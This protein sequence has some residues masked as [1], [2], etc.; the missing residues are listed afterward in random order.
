MRIDRKGL[1]WSARDAMRAAQPNAMLMTF[2]YLL[3]TA[4][5]TVVVGLLVTD[6]VGEVM[7]LYQRGLPLERA[8][9]L[10]VAGVGSV[11]LFANILMFIFGLVV[12]FGYRNWCLAT[13]RGEQGELGN[14][15]DGFSMVG[16]IL[17]LRILIMLY[18]FL[19]YLAIFMP[20]L[21]GVLA[22]TLIPGIGPLV[23][24][25]VFLI[26]VAAYISR[27]LRYS[28]S[29]YCLADEPEMGASWALRRSKWMMEGHVKDYFLLR[30]S[31][32]GW[33][34]LG[35]LLVTAVEGAV[36]AV[37]GG[38]HLLMET[39]IAVLEQIGN[40]A[41]MTVSLALASWPL[42]VWLTPYVALTECKFY[43]QIKDKSA[44]QHRF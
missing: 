12:D 43:D 9:P 19:W 37:M 38:P 16:R 17:W 11:G 44:E 15:I 27:I 6:P 10:A 36:I 22:G 29:V 33:Y 8:I 32:I 13:A 5:L 20:A 40:S 14:L 26:A 24:V 25:G 39:D 4:G 18:G 30:L 42:E 31:F 35:M 1:K 3:L 34:V 28:M 21:L 23:S 7:H 41:V 2:V